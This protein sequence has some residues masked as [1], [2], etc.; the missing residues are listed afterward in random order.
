MGSPFDTADALPTS[1]IYKGVDL[2]AM[3]LDLPREEARYVPGR[4]WFIRVLFIT[5]KARWEDELPDDF[6]QHGTHKDAVFVLARS[7]QIDGTP[8]TLVEFRYEPRQEHPDGG[9]T[10]QGC[11]PDEISEEASLL[12][13]PITTHPKFLTTW[14][15]YWNWNLGKFEDD[16]GGLADRLVGI[17]HYDRGSF[18][19]R[20]T[21]YYSG[22]PGSVGDEVNTLTDPPGHSSTGGAQWKVQSGSVNQTGDCWQKTLV[23]EFNEAGW[24]EEIYD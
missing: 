7:A 21:K 12:Q 15:E 9:P 10:G 3:K 5:E 8:I 22:R 14:V 16:G 24:N 20:E 2:S 1:P 4:G 19:V 13:A 17:T 6:E 23:Y 18:L 11:P